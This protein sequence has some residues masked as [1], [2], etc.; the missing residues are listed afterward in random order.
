[1]NPDQTAHSVCNIKE[2]VHKQMS[3]QTAFAVNSGKRVNFE[4]NILSK[5]IRFMPVGPRMLLVLNFTLLYVILLA[6]LQA[7]SFYARAPG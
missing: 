5:A 3:E 2:H 6:R 7:F 4:R 1:M